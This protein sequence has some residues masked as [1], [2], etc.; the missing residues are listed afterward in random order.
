MDMTEEYE[1]YRH[2]LIEYIAQNIPKISIIPGLAGVIPMI[3]SSTATASVPGIGTQ[4][5]NYMKNKQEPL[6]NVCL[7]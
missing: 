5:A 7:G 6:I 3:G 1:K 4:L 2:D